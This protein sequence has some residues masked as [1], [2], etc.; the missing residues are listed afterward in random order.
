MY[1]VR[2]DAGTYIIQSVGNSV[3][4]S[5][6]ETVG[7]VILLNLIYPK[8][9]HLDKPLLLIVVNVLGKSR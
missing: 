4:A 5:E 1:A 8:P 6:A 9:L 3:N 7:G 2:A